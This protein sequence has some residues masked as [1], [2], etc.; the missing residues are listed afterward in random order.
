MWDCRFKYLPAAEQ[1]ENS[2]AE[3]QHAP[4]CS[5]TQARPSTYLQDL[6]RTAAGRRMAEG[7]HAFMQEFVARFDQE[8]QA[9]A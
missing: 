7:R 5:T 8:W 1:V 6:M 9:A 3:C 4:C 2:F